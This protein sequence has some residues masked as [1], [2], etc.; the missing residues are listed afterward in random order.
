MRYYDPCAFTV[1]TAG[2]LGTAARNVLLGP[3]IANLD[4]SLTKETAIKALGES[5]GLEFRAE[6]FN[7]LN[8]ANFAEPNRTVFAETNG[9]VALAAAGV[10]SNTITPSRQI[11]F[12]LRLVF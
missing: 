9:S 4:F 12:A 8:R 10:I 1:Q 6:I 11:Q 5:G 3:G 7:I 2:F